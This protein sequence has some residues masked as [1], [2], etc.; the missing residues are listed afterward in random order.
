L[1]DVHTPRI[2]V[3]TGYFAGMTE[4][5]ILAIN[6]R[7]WSVKVRQLAINAS[8]YVVTKQLENV[9]GILAINVSTYVATCAYYERL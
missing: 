4:Q 8:T 5:I 9:V 1:L 2:Y 7:K 3:A 6:A